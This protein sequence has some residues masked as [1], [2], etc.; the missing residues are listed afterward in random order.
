MNI[1]E[2]F[3]ALILLGIT[4]SF[5]LFFGYLLVEKHEERKQLIEDVRKLKDKDDG[6]TSKFSSQ[7]SN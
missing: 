6:I 2:M 1:I 4:T 3:G 5:S 7:H